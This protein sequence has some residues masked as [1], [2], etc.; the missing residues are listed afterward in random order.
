PP[1]T[2]LLPYT[3]LFRSPKLDRLLAEQAVSCAWIEACPNAVGGGPLS[4]S[5]LRAM[6]ELCRRAGVPLVLDASRLLENVLLCPVLRKKP[7]RKST[8][9]NSSHLVI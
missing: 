3:T 7:D 2:S 8:R 9:L 1:A 6:L 5:N 4:L